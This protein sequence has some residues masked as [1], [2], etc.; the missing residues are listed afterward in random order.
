M[1]SPRE[2]LIAMQMKANPAPEARVSLHNGGG[3]NRKRRR[4]RRGYTHNWFGHDFMQ[5]DVPGPIT[6]FRA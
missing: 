2:Q 3:Y 1:T 6:R 4:R 5:Q